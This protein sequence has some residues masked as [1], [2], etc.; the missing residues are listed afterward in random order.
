VSRHVMP[1]ANPALTGSPQA[2]AL[3]LTA[4]LMATGTQPGITAYSH[5]PWC[6]GSPVHGC[7]HYSET[8]LCVGWAGEDSAG[9]QDSCC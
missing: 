1:R 8:G 6:S 9:L 2:K 3:I 7:S 4:L 5:P